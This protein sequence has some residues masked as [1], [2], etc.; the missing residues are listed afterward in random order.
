MKLP[1]IVRRRGP[2]KL[3][4][5]IRLKNLKPS[6]QKILLKNPLIRD[7]AQNDQYIQV[8]FRIADMESQHKNQHKVYYNHHTE[9]VT[10]YEDV[11][12]AAET[13]DWLCAIC[14]TPIKANMYDFHIPNFVCDKCG[15]VHNKKNKRI[16]TRIL[17]SSLQ[18]R[19]HGKETLIKEQQRYLSY[20]KRFE[21]GRRR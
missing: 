2:F 12:E 9:T 7:Y 20:I 5:G 21:E 14:K 13:I 18:F 17:E 1:L 15:K 11:V 6:H 10:Q 3:Q 4:F 16:D 8:L 19:Q